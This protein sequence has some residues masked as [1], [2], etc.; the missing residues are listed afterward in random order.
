MRMFHT[1]SALFTLCAAPLS[2]ADGFG[3][4]GSAELM[5]AKALAFAERSAAAFPGEYTIRIAR[6]PT[7]PPLKPGAVAFEPERISK[8]EPI[9]RFF[10]VFRVSVD[11]LPA[12]T[13]R[14]ELESTWSGTL[15][16]AKS[17]L[18]RKT[19]LTEGELEEIHFDGVPVAGAVKELPKGFRLRQ[20]IRTGK[21]LTLM[22]IEPI[23]LISAMDRVRVTLK[24]GPLHITSE[25]TARSSG[26]KGDRVRLEMEGSRKPVQAVVT[27]PG[28]AIIELRGGALP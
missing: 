23:P 14:V 9:G 20:P 12:A 11:G 7:L 28:Q 5:G 2:A 1:L 10:V 15:Y 21:V 17:A 25:A 19:V 22:D 24:N 27:G 4:L 8:Q 3:A 26:A 18:Q 13:A 6:P 16:Q